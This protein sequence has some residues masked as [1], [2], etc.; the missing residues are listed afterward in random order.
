MLVESA[1]KTLTRKITRWRDAEGSVEGAG[2]G[3]AM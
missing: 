1:V 3:I 2:A